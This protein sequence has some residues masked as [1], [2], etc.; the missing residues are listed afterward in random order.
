LFRRTN[1]FFSAPSVPQCSVPSVLKNRVTIDANR[2]AEQGVL[3]TKSNL[4]LP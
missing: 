3:Y 1:H 2:S 4:K